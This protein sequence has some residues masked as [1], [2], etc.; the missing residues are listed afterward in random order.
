MASDTQALIATP[1]DLVIVSSVEK[2]PLNIGR[3]IPF[4]RS[5]LRVDLQKPSIGTDPQQSLRSVLKGPNNAK[6]AS[7][8]SSYAEEVVVNIIRLERYNMGNRHG[9]A[10]HTRS[11]GM[12]RYSYRL[13]IVQNLIALQ[14][15]IPRRVP[16]QS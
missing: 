13:E 9:R 4:Y 15:K 11:Y 2:G 5:L 6:S 12:S 7:V 10:R 1:H 3:E 14:F 8:V 16:L